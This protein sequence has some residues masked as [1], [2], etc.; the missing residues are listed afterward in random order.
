[1]TI[2][3]RATNS[4]RK[5]GNA[6][7]NS[8]GTGILVDAG[9]ASK[10]CA[11]MIARAELL[12]SNLESQAELCRQL[13]EITRHADGLPAEWS[14]VARE[15]SSL[16]G[17]LFPA[18]LSNDASASSVKAGGTSLPGDRLAPTRTDGAEELSATQ[19]PPSVPFSRRAGSFGDLVAQSSKRRAA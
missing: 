3:A 15:M 10:E 13:A 17:K 4:P 2:G 1:M 11:S 12:R 18:R 14:E 6:G 19:P 9:S 16:V 7:A 5:N 8:G